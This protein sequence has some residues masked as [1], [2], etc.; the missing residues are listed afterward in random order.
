MTI[1]PPA[2][3]TA[4]LAQLHTEGDPA[5]RSALPKRY[6]IH[7]D[8]AVGIPMARLKAIAAPHAPNPGLAE[9][10]WSSGLYEARTIAAF[11]RQPLNLKLK[12]AAPSM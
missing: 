5:V 4:I 6:G 12:E 2:Q 3:L 10:L 8:H 1:D 11:V 7:T 9:G